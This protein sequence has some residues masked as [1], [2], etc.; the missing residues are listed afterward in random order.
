MPLEMET[1]LSISRSI[2]SNIKINVL[3]SKGTTAC[4][5]AY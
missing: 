2:I 3:R 5:A 4:A 1:K